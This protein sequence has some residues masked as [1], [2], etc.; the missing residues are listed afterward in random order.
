MRKV[1]KKDM[2]QSGLK[3]GER[4]RGQESVGTGWRDTVAMRRRGRKSCRARLP[5]RLLEDRGKTVEMLMGLWRA[6][7]F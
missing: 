5:T 3:E 4:P 2:V 6:S 1:T 7:V